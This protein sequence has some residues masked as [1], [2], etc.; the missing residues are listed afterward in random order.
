MWWLIHVTLVGWLVLC[1]YLAVFFGLFGL[2]VLRIFS[3]HLS[4]LTS[5]LVIPA[6]WVSLEY[7]RSHLLSGLGWNLLAYSQTPWH[8]LIQLADVTGVWGVS[9]LIVLVNA[10]TAELIHV[11][12]TSWQQ[13]TRNKRRRRSQKKQL[14]QTLG[15]LGIAVGIVLISFCYGAWR[16]QHL[17]L[18]PPVR[19]AVVQGNI[20]QAEKWDEQYI[21]KIRQRY[22]QLT[23]QAARTAPDLIVW[24][25]TSVPGYFGVDEVLTQ[26]VSGLAQTAGRPLL[27]GA[28]ILAIDHARAALHNSAVLVD[29]QGTIQQQHDKLHLVPFGEFIPFERAAPW[30]RKVLPP[31]GDFVPGQEYTVFH[32][33][34]GLR[35]EGSGKSGSGFRVVGSWR[36]SS[37]QSPEPTTPSRSSSEPRTQ[38]P[39]LAFSVLVCFEDVFPELAR[40]F[41]RE[42]ARLLLVITNDAW[43][44]PTAA[45]YQ[46]TQ[47]STFRAIELRVPVARA[48]NTGWSGCIDATGAWTGS[49]RDTQGKELFVEGT[50]TCDLAIG[51]VSTLYLKWGD[52]FAFLCLVAAAASLT[53]R[54]RSN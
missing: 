1:A 7:L 3:S 6:A 26:W 12:L 48:A 42:G 43:F 11:I 25:E 14:A 37:A 36:T 23:E 18:D 51:P 13:A 22:T 54:L 45:A 16:L 46:H 9:F 35:A 4:P 31:I 10:S 40:R 52:W 2:I 38:S 32:L 20:P 44:G 21:N 50:H 24:P 5:H 53:I 33:G 17:E 30:L 28:P 47:A 41:V 39:E 19:I 15:H 49:V 27:V 29:A 34:S 8:Q